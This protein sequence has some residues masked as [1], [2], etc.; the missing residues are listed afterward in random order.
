M[1]AHLLTKNQFY[2]FRKA[3]FPSCFYHL[4]NK[5]KE[6][7]GR[8]EVGTK[9]VRPRVKAIDKLYIVN[10]STMK[11]RLEQSKCQI[12]GECGKIIAKRYR[13]QHDLKHKMAEAYQCP[14]CQAKMSK[15]QFRKH[16]C[17]IRYE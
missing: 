3:L 2:I 11:D 8:T 10:G 5:F 7:D 4:P 12:C 17:K 6:I 16:K 9:K 14:L 13:K 1:D 15:R